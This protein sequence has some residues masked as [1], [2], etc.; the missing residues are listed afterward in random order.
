M[1]GPNVNRADVLDA[2]AVEPDQGSETLVRYLQQYPQYA[3][4]LV[5]LSRELSR[6]GIDEAAPLS[7]ADQPRIEEAWQQYRDASVVGHRD[8]LSSLTIDQRRKAADGLRVPRQVI[9]ALI[10]RRVISDSMPRRTLRRLADLLDLTVEAFLESLRG[11]AVATA[12]SYKANV[13]PQT[14]SQVTFERI[15]IEADVPADIRAELLSEGE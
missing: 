12:R 4:E 13:K 10:E 15:L 1:S 14:A 7:P 5:D 6:I 2:F 3:E 11:P 9:T 8:L